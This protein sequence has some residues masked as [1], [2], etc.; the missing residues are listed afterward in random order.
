MNLNQLE[1]LADDLLS[2][3]KRMQSLSEVNSIDLDMLQSRCIAV[4]DV[5]L[6]LKQPNPAPGEAIIAQE[7]EKPIPPAQE[8]PPLLVLEDEF[9][10]V[11]PAPQ[12]ELPQV[13]LF[14]TTEATAEKTQTEIQNEIIDEIIE[15]KQQQEQLELPVL[16][17]EEKQELSLHEKIAGN[18][19]TQP[20]LS[21]RLS[22]QVA[23]LKAAI[24]VNLKIAIV[25][26]LFKE[27]TVEYVKAIDKLNNAAN[28]NDAMRF[29]TELKHTY[30]WSN[31]NT[32]VQE[33]EQLVQK[34]FH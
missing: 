18:I 21:E 30:S 13:D 11:P 32:L 27:N 15:L 8:Q 22:G 19:P 3:V 2:Q 28:Y 33:L 6:Q 31:E 34:R 14:N 1:H 9:V 29:F 26:D 4:Y 7:E 24:N 17:T 5:I 20:D 10:A 16:P 12:I 23:N 25:N